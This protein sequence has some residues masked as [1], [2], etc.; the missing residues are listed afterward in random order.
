LDVWN[1]NSAVAEARALN[2][3]MVELRASE[4]RL[5]EEV[6]LAE[7]LTTHLASGTTSLAAAADV[8]EP[9]LRERT[10]FESVVRTRYHSPTFRHGVARYLILR[11]GR[12]LDAAPSQ[13]AT[14]SARL[15]AE[16]SAL[17]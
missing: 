15:E 6:E 8:M 1:W 2:D 16:Y 14:A 3:R 5:R 7:G 9:I 11:V 13:W 10:G 17:R 12:Q 4:E